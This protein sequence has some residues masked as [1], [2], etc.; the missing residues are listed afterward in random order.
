MNS[1]IYFKINQ[2]L[3]YLKQFSSIYTII[4]Y[5]VLIFIIANKLL[6]TYVIPQIDLAKHVFQTLATI[7]AIINLGIFAKQKQYSL[8]LLALI[9]LSLGICIKICSTNNVILAFVIYGVAFSRLN[10]R[11]VIYIYLATV[12]IS[13]LIIGIFFFLE[14]SDELPFVVRDNVLR[15]AFGFKHANAFSAE[16]FFLCLSFWCLKNSNIHNIL[17]IIICVF[18]FFFVKKYTLSR[19]PQIMLCL[20]FIITVVYEIYYY[21]KCDLSKFFTA[22]LIKNFMIV[23]FGL[24]AIFII[25]LSYFYNPN[26]NILNSLNNILSYRLSFSYKSFDYYGITFFGQNLI[27]SD[28]D[29]Y[30]LDSIQVVRFIPLDSFYIWTLVCFGIVSLAI[31]AFCSAIITYKSISNGVY[32]IAIALFCI[33][34][35]ALLENFISSICFN[36]FYYMWMMS[37]HKR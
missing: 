20:L 18:C 27:L 31:F 30:Y 26:V 21:L 8:I 12:L 4:A 29:P 15:E 14:L 1:N 7:I 5:V 37:F 9:A 13:S 28:S 11:Y 36:V 17:S 25:L 16:I 3:I 23:S 34:L 24:I 6:S 32:K 2:I 22:K 33:S 10:Y 19:T 35:Y